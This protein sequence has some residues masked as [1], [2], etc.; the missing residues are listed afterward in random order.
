MPA[1]F[2]LRKGRSET[3]TMV[4]ATLV[5][6]FATWALHSYQ[7]FW[8]LGKPLISAPDVLFWSVLAV[9]VLV[10]SLR[11]RRQGRIRKLHDR[12]FSARE[13][14][15]LGLRTATTFLIMT[16]LWTI[17]TSS[18][19]AEWVTLLGVADPRT[20]E[21]WLLLGGLFGGAVLIASVARFFSGHTVR[22]GDTGPGRYGPQVA[23]AAVG[24]TVLAVAARPGVT[25]RLPLETQQ[26]LFGLQSGDLNARDAERLQRGYYE[27]LIGVSALN[28]RLWEVYAKRP[29][30]WL[31]IHQTPAGR[32][33]TDFM[34]KELVPGA[35]ILWHGK[36]FRV[37]RWGM[38]DKDYERAPAP[39]TR[40]IALFGASYTIGS[41]VADGEVWESLIEDR[42]NREH[43][44]DASPVEVLNF[45]APG[46]VGFQHLLLL[47]RRALDLA[48]T[49]IWIV[50]YPDEALDLGNHIERLRFA[51][52]PMPWPYLDSVIQRA[53]LTPE[54]PREEVRRRLRPFARELFEW[55]MREI[56]ARARPRGI[57]LGWIYLPATRAARTEDPYPWM[58]QTAREAG[59]AT[60][61]LRTVYEG[62][63]ME[64]IIVA[65]YD[66]HPNELGHRIIAD[67]L[68]PQIARPEF[69]GAP[70]GARSTP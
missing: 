6:F 51:G 17:W 57:T 55:T 45:A 34:E 49:A 68:Y 61:E 24:I 18:S 43:P 14:L 50:S 22:L 8:L 63:A 38:R 44:V 41:G 54:L 15:S 46:Y 1:F 59:F 62:H 69:L 31:F 23:M 21:F 40:R 56:A 3:A 19:T 58:E 13:A 52:V 12:G 53:G 9:L 60:A 32:S 7:W 66:F 27:N 11:E 29:D 37:N 5:A 2:A 28:S 25:R 20:A 36:P 67:M 64:D 42:L 33:T 65:P 35:E 26:V 4:I 10:D 47:D 16:V 70:A 39:G 48:P 30:D